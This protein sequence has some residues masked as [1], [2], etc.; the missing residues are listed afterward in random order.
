MLNNEFLLMNKDEEILRFTSEK[1]EFQEVLLE[2]LEETDKV[3]PIGFGDIQSF[4]ANRQAPKHRKHIAE[5]LRSTGCEDL[6][7]FIRLTH[8][9]S[10]NDTY[11]VKEAG[12]KLAWTEVSL[13]RNDF[14]EVVAQMAFEG[15]VY[16][17]EF[18]PTSPEYNTDGTYAKCWV[19]EPEGIFLIKTGLR[20]EGIEPFS[21]F[22]S[23][24]IANIICR[25]SVPYS[26]GM[27]HD[28]LVSKCPLFT[29]EEEGYVPAVK[30]LSFKDYKKISYLLNYF[31]EM[32]FEDEF[33]RM[34]VLDALIVNDDRHPGNYGFI[35]DN[36]TQQIKRM[37]PMFDHNHSL[38]YSQE[39]DCLSDMS[40]YLNSV[41]PKI[42]A[43]FNQT[44]NLVLTP[45]IKSD[46]LNMR[47]FTF[48]RDA[49]LNLPEQRLQMLEGFINNQIDN[50]LDCR[51]LYFYKG[52]KKSLN[53]MI[54]EASGKSD[55]GSKGVVVKA[56]EPAR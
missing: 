18:S 5:L 3:L 43:D 22:Y 40:S 46:L 53:E 54:E 28:K 44:A 52:V 39:S 36:Q 33:R 27:Y 7:G 56:K 9:L 2:Q 32:G 6:D 20:K 34:L 17:L 47:G 8:A 29:S 19:R 13:Y 4:I 49:H 16:D 31:S 35:V 48:Q 1:N 10:L 37:A 25:D 45:E 50:I 42:G 51:R 55:V 23:S 21:E 24:Q 38:F 11:W 41:T 14:N 15:G 30:L 12:S 26:I